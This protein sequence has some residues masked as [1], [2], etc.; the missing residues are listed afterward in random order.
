MHS[1]GECRLLQGGFAP[2]RLL[3]KLDFGDRYQ[4]LGAGLEV[5]CLQQRLFLRRSVWRHHCQR[6]NQ[7]LVGRILDAVPIRLEIVRLEEI[8]E[9]VQQARAVD[10]ILA[11]ASGEI[12]D[13]WRVGDAALAIERGDVKLL[14]DAE[15]GNPGKLQQIPP[16]A[17]LGDLGDAS[18]AADFEQ[19]RLVVGPRM[20]RV[21]LDH[22]DQTMP[23]AQR[24][25]D[26]RQIARLEDVEGH[27]ATRQQQRSRQRKHR[28]HGG[29]V[30]G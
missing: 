19:V 26:H 20:R 11:L 25:V 24:V 8:G 15:A 27:L 4:D 17:G 13:E 3:R 16:V 10:L 6:V 2:A 7:G 9:R 18:D 22:A 30:A 5:G 28:D 12:V 14:L 23:A 21:G 1:G 29:K